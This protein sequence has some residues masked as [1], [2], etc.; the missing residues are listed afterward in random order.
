MKIKKVYNSICVFVKKSTKDSLSAYAAQTTFFLLL[1]FV[2]IIIIL[3]MIASNV[4]FLWNNILDYIL[5]VVPDD[6]DK[7]VYYVVDDI[8]YTDNKTF[9]I[10]TIFLALWTSARSVQ[11]LAYGLDRIYGA[12]R[13][14]NFIIT[15]LLSVLYMFVLIIL[16]MVAMLVDIFSS[17]I[18]DAII[19]RTKIISNTTVI[20]MSFRTLFI[21]I[22]LFIF[23]LLIYYHLPDRKGRFRE[24]V[25]GA[26]AASGGLIL[27]T[28]IFSFYIKYIANL[29]Y[30]Y[31]GLASVV[32][33]V[34][35]LY[36]AIQ[37]ILYG[38]QLNYYLNI[39]TK[40]S[41]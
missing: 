35:W 29:S 31:G 20:V 22:I 5:G 11:S 15:R 18:L 40:K 9:T 17:Q 30:M 36:T 7:Y 8:V 24:E 26:A 27:M 12:R 34:I 3:F 16:C 1:S 10:T 14:K 32:V 37:I 28:K 39:D 41:I 33:L 25:Y 6:M 2:P 13:E 38:A 4:S 19:K 23:I 21:F